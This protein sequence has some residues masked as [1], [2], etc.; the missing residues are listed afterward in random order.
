MWAVG[1]ERLLAAHRH[2]P[3]GGRRVSQ[4]GSP[5]L[6]SRG[7]ARVSCWPGA[8]GGQGDV[9]CSPGGMRLVCGGLGSPCGSA[10]ASRVLVGACWTPLPWQLP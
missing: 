7:C 5:T 9:T 3:A 10:E 6:Q 1:E 8:A 4:N 2:P